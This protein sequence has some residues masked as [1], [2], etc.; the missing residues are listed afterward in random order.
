MSKISLLEIKEILGAE[1]WEVVSTEY[2][3]L[4]TEMTFQCPE[5]HRV[6]TTWKR[7]RSRRECPVCKQNI[8]K[9]QEAKISRK[10]SGETRLLAIDQA[11][12]VSG[13]SVY[14]DGKLL[15]YGIFETNLEDE[16]QR[17]L[18]V[19][20]WMLSMINNWE[21]D[22]VALE[23]IQYEEE[24]GVKT[25]ATLARLQGILMGCLAENQVPYVVCPTPTWRSYCN[26]KGR[27]RG[28]KKRSMQLIVKK[29][30][31]ITITDDCADAIGI[32][33]YAYHNHLKKPT[34]ENWE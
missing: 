27:T 31:D 8:F 4:D 21:P 12:R 10:K 3:N 2:K 32:G 25:F 18:T 19:K 20:N 26:V 15:R 1:N 6:Y 34:I 23:G 9:E 24:Y 11:T 28:D 22:M 16:I 33:H 17:D 5:K 29:W 13:W 7:L 14:S 30:H